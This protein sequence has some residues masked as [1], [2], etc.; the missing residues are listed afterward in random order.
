M[1]CGWSG[2]LG[3]D[4]MMVISP[5]A[6]PDGSISSDWLAQFLSTWSVVFPPQRTEFAPACVQFTNPL[7]R[8]DEAISASGI[9]GGSSSP[10]LMDPVK[11]NIGFCLPGR[12]FRPVFILE[13]LLLDGAQRV[14]C[15]FV[16]GCPG[17]S[18]LCR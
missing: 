7:A 5:N 2:P 1:L 13:K 10:V 4:G 8:N 12:V 15:T 9:I 6:C 16:P 3:D 18:G 17:Y 11:V 14:R